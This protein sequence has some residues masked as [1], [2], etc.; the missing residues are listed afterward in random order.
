M[1]RGSFCAFRGPVSHRLSERAFTRAPG[2][3]KALT[4]FSTG[5]ASRAISE[6]LD[7]LAGWLTLA[8]VLI[9]FAG[10][11]FPFDFSL[12]DTA[13]RRVGFFLFWF[14]PVQKD[15][16]GWLLNVVLF[17]PFGFGLAW[18]ARVRGWKGLSRPIAIG[19]AGFLFSYAV[20]FLQLFVVR[21]GS[22]WDDVVMNTAGALLGRL[23][24]QRWG[25]RLLRSAEAVFAGFIAIFER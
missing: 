21:R 24:C 8:V 7:F 6:R 23:L 1:E 19:A 2:T 17:L 3:D 20:E 12:A 15:W 11:L 14:A 22:S 4:D 16:G 25:V 13:A 9:I 18:W 10:T 5:S